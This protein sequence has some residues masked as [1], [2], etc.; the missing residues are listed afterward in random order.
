VGPL[1]RQM[2]YMAEAWALCFMNFGL[3]NSLLIDA[4]V[5]EKDYRQGCH[6]PEIFPSKAFA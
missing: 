2:A 4:R 3:L 5:L 6:T 1:P